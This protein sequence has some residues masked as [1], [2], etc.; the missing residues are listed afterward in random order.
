MQRIRK[1]SKTVIILLFFL[2]LI[3]GYLI[4]GIWKTEGYQIDSLEA[5]SQGFKQLKYILL[6]PFYN[7]WSDK[8]P[9]ALVF[10]LVMWLITLVYYLD[11]V[12]NFR[13]GAE[14]GTAEWG[15]I[16]KMV[17]ELAE[18][19]NARN[20]ILSKN[21]KMSINDR[22]T[23]LNSN[24]IIVGGSGAGKSAFFVKPNIYQFNTSFVFTDPK[25][26]L[27][28]DTG[29]LLLRK[30]YRVKVLNFRNLS[31][32]DG[33]NPFCYIREEEDIPRLI[34]NL[35]A[36]TTP[37]GSQTQDP[38]WEK[39]ES[40]YLQSLLF[41]VWMEVPGG[42]ISDVLD[43]MAKAQA[44][45]GEE[46]ELDEIFDELEIKKGSSHPAVRK[47]REAVA[48]AEDTIRSVIVCANSRMAFLDTQKV[49]S[50]FNKDEMDFGS[51]GVGPSGN[52]SIKTALFLV[53]PALDKTY[54]PLVGMAYTQMFQELYYQA[55]EVRGTGRLPIPVQVYMD[56][57]ANVSQPENFLNVISTC[58]SYNL[59]INVILQN[60]AQL[61]AQFK[62]SWKTIVGNCDTF[63]YL[64][65]NEHD[66][67]EYVSK[68]LGKW[69][70]DKRSQ[71]RSFGS[72]GSSSRSDDVLGRELMDS[73]EVRMLK[74]RECILLIASQRP[75][76]DAKFNTFQSKMHRLSG[77]LGPY[78][79]EKDNK[80]LPDQKDNQGKGSPFTYVGPE[81]LKYY[82]SMAENRGDAV[83]Y[84]FDA[85]DL[86]F[87][88]FSLQEQLDFCQLAEIIKQNKEKVQ[89]L[90]ELETAQAAA[91]EGLEQI[92]YAAS[93]L[94]IVS[95]YSF[96]DAQL[97]QISLGIANGLTEDQI[98]H[99]YLDLSYSPERM[100]ILRQL[101]E[102]ESK[103]QV[104]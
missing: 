33:Y 53:L 14:H 104:S 32:S 72:H 47:Y 29:K 59:S 77:T 50:I 31:E 67:H 15:N 3:G 45:E 70:L 88:D 102:K 92:D 69:T 85:A 84:S 40:L 43:L 30:G 61:E 82:Q 8:T 71:S 37:K 18:K 94:S 73:Q 7:W 11:N 100:S 65:G 56:E 39:Y 93:L 103:Q 23:R 80:P 68:M 52:S 48:G 89:K 54:N 22:Y 27:L 78:R 79:H 81:G 76:I 34:N 66:S 83:L 6:H 24:S 101:A 96:T 12:K 44:E 16:R 99:T 90:Q 2:F 10:A 5:L 64:G 60:L 1:P 25:G 19:D 75:I 42:T 46:S 35:I 36:N 28:R 91:L 57:F 51:L 62:D 97:E 95:R 98:K 4:G 20:K 87:Y 17:K 74:R 38:F 55:D 41:Y 21:V 49:K 26:E 58:R 13:P 63:I 9:L 86:L